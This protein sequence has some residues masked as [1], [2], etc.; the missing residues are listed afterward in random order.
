MVK[1]EE[2][3]FS[4]HAQHEAFQDGI[5]KSEI[6]EAIKRG[7]SETQNGHFITIYKYFTVVYRKLPHGRYKIIT[8]FAG[9]PRTWRKK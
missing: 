4:E 9:Y 5:S 6:E 8:V 3:V 2:L 7:A 1:K